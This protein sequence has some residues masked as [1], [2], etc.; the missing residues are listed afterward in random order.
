MNLSNSRQIFAASFLLL[1][2]GCSG[3][4]SNNNR[5]ATE[6]P[7]AEPP[8]NQYEVTVLNLTAGQPFSP[9]AVIGHDSTYSAFTIGQAASNGL[10][11]L[12]EGGNNTDF[13]SEAQ[14]DMGVMD[15]IGNGAVVPPGATGTIVLSLTEDQVPGALISVVTMLVNTNDAITAVLDIS[16]GDLEVGEQIQVTTVTYDVGTEANTEEAG[17][18]PG[19]ADGGEGFNSTRDDIADQV[20]GHAGVV[21][22]ADGLVGSVLQE[23]HRWDNPVALMT[24]S[25]IE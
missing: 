13:L 11:I 23:V 22:L 14:S 1:I 24:I 5:S 12:A 19:P 18:I 6:S 3:S 17:T 25:R 21:T 15:V 7:E 16:V 4:S 10:E 8:G 2:V 20:R 9:F